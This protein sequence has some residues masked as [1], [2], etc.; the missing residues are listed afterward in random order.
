[1]TE[2]DDGGTGT[3]KNPLQMGFTFFRHMFNS[4]KMDTVPPLPDLP[5]VVHGELMT[6]TS[7]LL[8]L[9]A[10]AVWR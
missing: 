8:S 10:A 5:P 4:L 2:M 3:R 1:M 7:V 6:K 9:L